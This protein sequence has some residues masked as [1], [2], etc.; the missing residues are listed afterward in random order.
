M[1][2][3]DILTGGQSASRVPP[4]AK[5]LAGLLS[6]S[7]LKK[8]GGAG[9]AGAAGPDYAQRLEEFFKPSAS[10]GPTAKGVIGALLTGGMM[11][12]VQQ[13]RGAGKTAAVESWVARGPNETVSP[14]ELAVVLTEDQIAFLMQRTG[15]SRQE[16]LAGLSERLPQVVDELTP[17]GRVPT[18]E[19]MQRK[20]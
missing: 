2:L 4:I 17:E 8:P 14:G 7:Q 3:L 19:E 20:V 5:A 18:A 1:A 12:L 11:D 16:L 10:G 6:Y 15:M 9:A 13:F